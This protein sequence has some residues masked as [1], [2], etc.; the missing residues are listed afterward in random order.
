MH[1]SHSTTNDIFKIGAD[2]VDVDALMAGIRES[3]T[4]K[5]ESGVYRDVRVAL[6]EKSNLV[7]IKD[8]ESFLKF[9]IEC[10]RNAV[11]V[12]INDFEIQERRRLGS[13]L[14]VILKKGMWALLK[15]YTYRLWSQQNQVNGLLLTAIEGLDDKYRNRIR[16]METR[17]AALEGPR[18]KT[19]SCPPPPSV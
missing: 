5:M 14:L 15:F 19:E 16:D 3:V 9:Y 10:L 4:R 17:L 18:G 11:F 8:D 2:G 6:A 7:N 12:D 13:G 1:A